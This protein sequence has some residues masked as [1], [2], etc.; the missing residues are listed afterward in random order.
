MNLDRLRAHYQ[1]EIEWLETTVGTQL[2]SVLKD[3]CTSFA[4]EFAA[5]AALPKAPEVRIKEF[6][7]IIEKLPGRN[8]IWGHDELFVVETGGTVLAILND[9]VAGR[10][11]CATHGDVERL[12]GI[13]CQTE[14]LSECRIDRKHIKETGYRAIHVDG[15]VQVIRQGRHVHF[16]VEVQVKTL[17]QDAWASFGHPEFYKPEEEPPE[18]SRNIAV[19]LADVL[20]GIDKIGQAIRDEKHRVKPGPD[21]IGAEER[22]ITNRTLRFVAAQTLSGAHGNGLSD[23]E[24][25]QAVRQLKAYGY[26]SVARVS[27]LFEDRRVLSELHVAR[28]VVGLQGP[29]TAFEVSYFGPVVV[30]D[31]QVAAQ[32]ELRRFYRFT[33]HHCVQCAAGISQ[34]Q[35]HFIDGRT[36]LD[37]EYLCGRCAGEQL[38]KCTECETLTLSKICK[39][40]ASRRGEL[41]LI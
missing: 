41:E 13:V 4:K 19:Y 6:A 17:L 34:E 1:G 35:K 14:A 32:G 36:D 15:R 12:V 27:G 26:D 18:I 21:A 33:E 5:V 20:D 39:N 40:C 3:V 24:V 22:L 8:N 38:K 25:E 16:P 2:K 29:L 11:V 10:I 7:R 28:A 9:L 31:G 30:R 37:S 23:V